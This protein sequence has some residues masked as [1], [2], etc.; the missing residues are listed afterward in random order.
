MSDNEIDLPAK[1]RICK[2]R[3]SWWVIHTRCCLQPTHMSFMRER[4]SHQD[5][6][7]TARAH[8]RMHENRE[9]YRRVGQWFRDHKAR[10]SA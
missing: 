6:V 7:L 9:R 2:V 8:I 10:S 3:G 4:L 1:I 5:A